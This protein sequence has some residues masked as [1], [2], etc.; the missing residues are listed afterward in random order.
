MA[1]GVGKD[2]FN[3]GI[4]LSVVLPENRWIPQASYHVNLGPLQE[5]IPLNELLSLHAHFLQNPE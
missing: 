5:V 4:S 2:F 3:F 1:D